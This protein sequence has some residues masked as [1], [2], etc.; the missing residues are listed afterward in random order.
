MIKNENDMAKDELTL[1]IELTP[2]TYGVHLEM[3]LPPLLYKRGGHPES[4]IYRRTNTGG[5]LGKVS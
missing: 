4:V 3:W 5:E 2:S 1:G